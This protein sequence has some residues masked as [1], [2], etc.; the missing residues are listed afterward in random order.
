MQL[1]FSCPKCKQT[2]QATEGL[3]EERYRCPGC[4]DE[5]TVPE[6]AWREEQLCRCL[7]CGEKDLWRQKD[8]PHAIGLAIVGMG[9]LLSTIAWAQYRPLI[10]IGILML[11]ALAD[12]ALYSLMRDVLV[13][14]RCHARHR[15]DSAVTEY[16]R[17]SHETAERY[18]Q[19][20]IRQKTQ[21][22]PTTDTASARRDSGEYREP[23]S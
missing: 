3:R 11:F 14:Y 4:G 1:V 15:L 22:P 18:R 6:S 19:D 12:L 20:A 13:C 21:H 16:D 23:S 17:F 8:F 5:R 7:A 10:A 2:V 9:I